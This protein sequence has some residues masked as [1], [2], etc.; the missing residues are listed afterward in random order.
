MSER[1]SVIWENLDRVVPC[2]MGP[3]ADDFLRIRLACTERADEPLPADLA[4]KVDRM[5]ALIKPRAGEV[6]HAARRAN[7]TDAEHDELR[8]LVE[9]VYKACEDATG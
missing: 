5:A 9:D 2:G 6:T 7:M 3:V 4:T 1:M 8:R